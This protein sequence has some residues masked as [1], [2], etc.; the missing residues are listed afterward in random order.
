[1]KSSTIKEMLEKNTKKYSNNIAFYEKENKVYKGI[2]YR[3]LY[4]DITNLG[5]KLI[6][7]DLKDKNIAVIGKNSYEWA[8]AYLTTVCGLGTVIPL[9]KELTKEE[10]DKQLEQLEIGAIIYSNEQKNK[11]NHEKYKTINMQEELPILIEKGKNLE[12]VYTNIEIEPEKICSYIFT[13][14]TTG[15]SKIVMLN[16]RNIMHNINN[17]DQFI[18]VDEKD[19]FFSILP[20]NHTFECTCGFL[21]PLSY[22]ASIIHLNSLKNIQKDMVIMKPTIIIGVPRILTMFDEKIT[23]EIEKKGKTKLVKYA[24]IITNAIPPL[25]KEIFKD[26]HESFGSNLRVMLV[27]GAPVDPLVSKRLRSYGFT[28]LQGYGLTECAPLVAGNSEKKFKDNKVG[29]AMRETDIK[30]INPNHEGIGEICVRGPQVMKGYYNNIEETKKSI[31]EEGFFHTGDL[32]KI[33]NNGFIKILG[34]SKN[35][36]ITSNGKN[37]YPEEI[38]SEINK[39]KYIKQAIVSAKD[40]TITVEIVLVDEIAKKIKDLPNFKQEIL[41]IINDYIK[42]INY[43]FAEYKRIKKVEI[44]EKPFEE[45]S[46]LKIKRYKNN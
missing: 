43:K 4:E 19:R 22:G 44:R 26:I 10:L 14:G 38:E 31:D 24:Q 34:R 13:S 15:D 45:T 20:M 36:I 33:D 11:I 28:V 6:N 41:K 17:V 8:L 40:N 42:E 37:V 1:M 5:N 7:E 12:D 30:I 2:T 25:K 39:N 16:N 21:A 46:T 3:Q 18:T 29:K 27:G 35:V 32:G 9:D 23:K